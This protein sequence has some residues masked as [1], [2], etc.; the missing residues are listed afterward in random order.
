MRILV[1]YASKSGTAEKLAFHI[2]VGCKAAGV[3]PDV[4][5]LKDS[6]QIYDYFGFLPRSAHSAK[7]DLSAYDLIFIGFE[8]HNLS[9]SAK[10][11]DFIEHND[12]QGKRVAL[13]CSYF[14]NRKYLAKI[15]EKLKRK[16]AAVFSTISL[17]RQGLLTL[18]GKG[19]LKENDLVRAEGFAERTVNN[20]AGRRITKESEKEQIRGYRK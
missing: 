14:I 9:E 2:V 19:E 4:I 16:S 12:F 18:L 3:L 10:L 20:L 15:E 7:H 1:A 8:I 11:L 6:F 17:K 13:F 5:D